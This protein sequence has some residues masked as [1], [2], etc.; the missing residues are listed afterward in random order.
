MDLMEFS[1]DLYENWYHRIK[2]SRS[3]IKTLE[4]F[5]LSRKN[6]LFTEKIN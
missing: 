4:V 3:V 6:I 2:S 5:F 1:K